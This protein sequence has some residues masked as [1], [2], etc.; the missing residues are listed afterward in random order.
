MIVGNEEMHGSFDD[1][2]AMVSEA[3]YEE[4]WYFNWQKLKWVYYGHINA[5]GKDIDHHWLGNLWD[6][7]DNPNGR[8]TETNGRYGQ[9]ETERVSLFPNPAKEF[10]T[11]D[12]HA[13][14]QS[15][16]SIYVLN[17][18][19]QK[20]FEKTVSE[21]HPPY[22]IIQTAEWQHGTYTLVI[23]NTDGSMNVKRLIVVQ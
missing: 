21:D 18:S 1:F 6:A 11:V 17:I 8:E 12:L 7:P 10:F 9:L 23:E 13:Y 2:E 14:D 19:G 3:V 20:V 22:E 15:I 4:R 5:D 16:R